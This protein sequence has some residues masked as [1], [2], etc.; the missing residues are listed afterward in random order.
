[1]KLYAEAGYIPRHAELKPYEDLA[2]R[3]SDED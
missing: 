1:M 2:E 3:P